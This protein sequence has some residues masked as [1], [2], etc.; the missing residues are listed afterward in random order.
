M[1]F[2]YSGLCFQHLC[3]TALERDILI[4]DSQDV[5]ELHWKLNMLI[6]GDR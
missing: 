5:A 2:G 6:K 4:I 1:L 3:H